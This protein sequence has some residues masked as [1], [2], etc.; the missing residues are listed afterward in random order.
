MNIKLNDPDY[1]A[2]KKLSI[3]AFE[4]GCVI[5]SN[6]KFYTPRDFLESD[7]KVTFLKSGMQE[8]SN[9]PLHYPKHA[10]ERKLEDVRKAQQ[11]LESFMQSLT[12]AF[13]F[14]PVKQ[15]NKKIK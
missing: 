6:G 9:C 7:V 1:E 8:Y 13:E 15:P 4:A 3:K 14:H 5:C 12:T 2:R 11:E 10:I